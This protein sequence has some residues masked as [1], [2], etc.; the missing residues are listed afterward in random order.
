[1]N[2]VRVLL[3]NRPRML[4][5]SLRGAIEHQADIEVELVEPDP[6]ELLAAVERTGADVVVITLPQANADPG[7]TSHLLNEYPD[8]LVIAVSPVAG[9][10]FAYRQVITKEEVVPLSS[11]TLLAAIRSQQREK[12]PVVSLRSD[13]RGHTS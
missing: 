4:R 1:M 3:G 7:L 10:A 6:L 8:L 11:A 2:T 5:E 13:S 12:P 9:S